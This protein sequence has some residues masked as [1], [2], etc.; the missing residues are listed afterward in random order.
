MN[1]EPQSS[2]QMDD[3]SILGGGKGNFMIFSFIFQINWKTQRRVNKKNVRGEWKTGNLWFGF[4]ILLLLHHSPVLFS[5]YLLFWSFAKTVLYSTGGT[6]IELVHEWPPCLHQLGRLWCKCQVST[7]MESV[8]LPA[9]LEKASLTRQTQTPSHIH[10]LS[11]GECDC[12]WQPP[13]RSRCFG[14][15][16]DSLNWPQRN[17]CQ[18]RLLALLSSSGTLAVF[19]S[20][21]E[22][23]CGFVQQW[24]CVCVCVCVRERSECQRVEATD[25]E[26]GKNMQPPG[27]DHLLGAAVVQMHAANYGLELAPK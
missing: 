15:L 17:I 6:W 1:H 26:A 2:N 16:A 24:A 3:S 18:A 20:S 10:L 12:Q 8:I 11:A 5:R 19:W 9:L 4:N 23:E 13:W 22:E 14:L 7:G 21:A 25:N 27:E